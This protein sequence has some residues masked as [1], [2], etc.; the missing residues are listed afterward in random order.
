MGFPLPCDSSFLCLHLPNRRQQAIDRPK[1]IVFQTE[2]ACLSDTKGDYLKDGLGAGERDGDLTCRAKSLCTNNNPP[3]W[4]SRRPSLPSAS[5]E[6]R[7]RTKVSGLRICA[8]HRLTSV[9]VLNREVTRVDSF[10]VTYES[11][12]SLRFI[13]LDA[14]PIIH[15]EKSELGLPRF[16]A[17]GRM[18]CRC[19][20]QSTHVCLGGLN[21]KWTRRRLRKQNTNSH[22]VLLGLELD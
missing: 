2:I 8:F 13:P 21:Q 18:M 12:T 1:V 22:H 14:E 16:C 5:P 3:I 6:W 15:D 10:L 19:W 9:K 20:V 11:A 17:N 4:K 7:W